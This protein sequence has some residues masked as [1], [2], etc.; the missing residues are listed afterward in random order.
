MTMTEKERKKR[1]NI[2]NLQEQ[3]KIL[4]R[5]LQDT[6]KYLSQQVKNLEVERDKYKVKIKELAEELRLEKAKNSG[7]DS[8]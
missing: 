7:G 8:L 2:R 1:E 5:K 3:N 6:Q 4:R